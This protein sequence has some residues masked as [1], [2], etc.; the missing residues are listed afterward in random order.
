MKKNKKNQAAV[1]TIEMTDAPKNAKATIKRLLG[2]L[3]QQ[4]PP[5][6]LLYLLLW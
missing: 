5:Y 3:T 1:N 2:L 6:L 4:K